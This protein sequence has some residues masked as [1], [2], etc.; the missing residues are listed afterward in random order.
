MPTRR[1]ARTDYLAKQGIPPI[2]AMELAS[3]YS[4]NQIRTLPYIRNM[5][6]AMRLYRSRL[7]SLNYSQDQIRRS[8]TYLFYKKNWL[9]NTGRPDVWAMLRSYRA[10]AIKSGGYTPPPKKKT[11]HHKITREDL[12]GQSTRRKS[13]GFDR[14]QILK[15][16]LVLVNLNL[17]RATGNYR[18]DLINE[19]K[20]LHQ[21]I[22]D[23][24]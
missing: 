3:H 15:D 17:K 8:V 24:K 22:K 5:V 10:A 1:G 6:R 7:A 9:G 18:D 11:S 19:R 13:K 21:R 23:L 14:L 12:A 2:M 4:M 20:S 16:R